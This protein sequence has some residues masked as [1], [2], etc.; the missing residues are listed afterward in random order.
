MLE[1]GF[2]AKEIMYNISR[3]Y[4]ARMGMG[5]IAYC[6]AIMH[7]IVRYYAARMGMGAIAYC[8]AIMV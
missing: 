2:L 3:Y 5:A 6:G 4:A 1:Q 8:E 7:N